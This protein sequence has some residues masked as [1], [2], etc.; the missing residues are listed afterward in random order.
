MKTKIIII[1]VIM[2]VSMSS[3]LVKSLHPFCEDKDVLYKPELLGTWTGRDSSAGEVRPTWE[4]KQHKLFGGFQKDE[5]QGIGYEIIYTDS[6]GKYKFLAR[7][8]S[9]DN[10]FYLD[11][12]LADMEGSDLAMMHLIM[13]HTLARVEI[14]KDQ[15]TIRWYNEEWLIKLF[16]ENRIR[17]AHE[18]IPFDMDD[19]NP[20]NFQVVLTAPTSDLKKFVQKYGNDP[21]AFD[22]EKNKS[23]YTFVLLRKGNGHQA[24]GIGH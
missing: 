10:H 22:N 3:C 5:K 18:R 21:A 19:K 6:K 7:L 17:I 12:Y 24:S 13:A 14:S 2:A 23:D 15:L 8:F 9:V 20:D 11:F 1:C 16:N 4:I